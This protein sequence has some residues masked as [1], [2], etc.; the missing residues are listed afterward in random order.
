M[1]RYGSLSAEY[2]IPIYGDPDVVAARTQA[3]DLAG[4]IGFDAIDQARIAIVT[5]ELARN[6]VLHAHCGEV[7]LEQVARQDEVGLQ[8]V[9]EDQGPG[10]EDLDGVL[11]DGQALEWGNG[12]GLHAAK[13]LMD[14]FEIRS[15]AG[16]GT[17][18]VVCK[19]LR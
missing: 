6:V 15:K 4:T 14:Q 10:I 8:I 13:R 11:N 18:V 17:T 1:E 2:R 3:R 7:V 9:C 5:S 12:L 16:R 19:W